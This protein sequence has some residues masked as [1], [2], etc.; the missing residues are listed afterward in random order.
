MRDVSEIVSRG[1]TVCRTCYIAGMEA[2]RRMTVNCF[3][4]DK[5][6]RSFVVNIYGGNGLGIM[7]VVFHVKLDD[8][9]FFFMNT[10]I[11]INNG[12]ATSKVFFKEWRSSGRKRLAVVDRRNGKGVF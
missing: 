7:K 6:I 4:K 3:L 9:Y 12:R 11:R 2:R 5:R 8:I 1:G 10:I